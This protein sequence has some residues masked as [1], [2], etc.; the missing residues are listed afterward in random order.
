MQVSNPIFCGD[1][2]PVVLTVSANDSSG[3]AGQSMDIRTQTALGVHTVS[4]ISA[5]TVQG[6]GGVRSINP[7]SDKL[8]E[9]QLIS[10]LELKPSAIKVGLLCSVSQIKTLA[11]FFAQHCAHIPIVVDPIFKS[12]SD[13]RFADDA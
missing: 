3:M 4:V 6:K 5:N 9:E 7:V 1:V 11:D 8:F 2:R 10:T 13:H 12:T